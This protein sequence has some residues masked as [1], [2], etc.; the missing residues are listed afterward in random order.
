MYVHA[1]LFDFLKVLTVCLGMRP[2]FIYMTVHVFKRTLAMF[3]TL[4]WPQIVKFCIPLGPII[5][6]VPDRFDDL[7]PFVIFPSVC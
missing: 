6:G 3:F 1:M 4:F 2:Y 5:K 7:Y